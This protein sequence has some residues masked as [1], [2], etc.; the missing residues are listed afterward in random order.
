VGVENIT[1]MNLKDLEEILGNTSEFGLSQTT[2]CFT[3]K[4]E[5]MI[6]A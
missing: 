5:L 3:G 4:G 1:D 6:D 2:D